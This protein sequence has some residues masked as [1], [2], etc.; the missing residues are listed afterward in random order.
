[1]VLC[2]YVPGQRLLLA[3]PPSHQLLPRPAVPHRHQRIRQA[4]AL[5]VALL[6]RVPQSLPRRAVQALRVALLRRV[7]QNRQLRAVPHQ[8]RPLR[9]AQNP[10]LQHRLHQ[11][12]HLLQAPAQQVAVLQ[13]IAQVLQAAPQSPAVQA[14][15]AH[16]RHSRR[17][18]VL[19]L[20]QAAPLE[21]LPAQVLLCHQQYLLCQVQVHH[22]LPRLRQEALL[23]APVKLWRPTLPLIATMQLSRSKIYLAMRHLSML[24]PAHVV[25]RP[26]YHVPQLTAKC[27][28][29]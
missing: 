7:P 24:L 3:V 5:R 1:M 13:P 26:E 14:V 6:R 2:Q 15:P 18:Q 28:K 9:Q 11:D 4:Q 29:L 20:P 16:R 17:V 23:P 22:Q 25:D 8:R 12:G 21:V 10:R 27:I 19:C